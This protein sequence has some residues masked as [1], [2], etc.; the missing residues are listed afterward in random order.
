MAHCPRWFAIVAFCF[1]AG[2]V[3]GGSADKKDQDKLR[4]SAPEQQ[5]LD[6]TNQERKQHDLPPLQPAPI[7]FKVAR[8]HSANMAKQEKMAHVL[9][10]KTPY[11]RIKGA[12]YAYRYSGENVAYGEVEL[13]EIMKAWMASPAHRDNIL[14]RKFTEIGLGLATSEK[15]EVYYTQVFATPKSKK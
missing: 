7:L 13:E 4:L 10:G 1:V 2:F 5:L 3:S 12:G 15:G 6:L 14:N 9:D 8:G 11:Q